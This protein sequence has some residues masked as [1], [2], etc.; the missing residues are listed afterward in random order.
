MVHRPAPPPPTSHRP[1]P[2]PPTNVS[3][4]RHRLHHLLSEPRRVD[5][6]YAFLAANYPL[7]KRKRHCPSVGV[8]HSVPLSPPSSPHSPPPPLPPSPSSIPAPLSASGA[9]SSLPPGVTASALRVIKALLDSPS[10]PEGRKAGAFCRDGVTLEMVIAATD[11]TRI[12]GNARRPDLH[13]EEEEAEEE[14]TE[15][16]DRTPERNSARQLEVVCFSSSN[17]FGRCRLQ[18]NTNNTTLTTICSYET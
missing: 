15:T 14:L 16:E 10:A 2:P 8:D 5:S 11:W 6:L 13:E 18:F 17:V 4:F 12:T 3:S 1:A 9:A 7:I